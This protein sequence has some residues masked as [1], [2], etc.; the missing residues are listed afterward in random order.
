MSVEKG[1]NIFEAEKAE[2]NTE[3]G[4]RLIKDVASRHEKELREMIEDNE[5]ANILSRI[6]NGAVTTQQL[7]EEFQ[8]LALTE[9]LD[10]EKF[11]IEGG[12]YNFYGHRFEATTFFQIILNQYRKEAQSISLE[13][14]VLESEDNSNKT[15]IRLGEEDNASVVVDSNES[16]EVKI[17]QRTN[18]QAEVARL[19]QGGFYDEAKVYRKVVEFAETIQ[20]AG[21]RAML[22]GGC[23]RDELMGILP[24]D[25]DVEVYG[26]EPDKLKQ[27][28]ESFGQVNE[29][30]IAFGILKI[31]V[32]D[33]DID[34][35]LPRRES[36]TGSGH[37]DFSISADPSMS[38]KEAARRRDF[39]FNALAKDVLTGEVHDYFGG[40]ND[41]EQ[42]IMRVTDEE[43]F[44]DDPLRV[45]RG[46]QF[47]GRYG[48]KVDDRSSEIMREMRG[49]LRHL[50]KERLREEWVKLFTRSRKPSLGLQ[51]AMEWGIFHE[52]HPELIELPKTPQ[53][54]E[55]HPE[56]DVWIHTMMVV[57]EAAKIVEREQLKGKDA[58]VVML[59][60]FCHDFGKPNTT[61]ESDGR[62]RALGHEEAGVEPTIKFLSEIGIEASLRDTVA[63][64]VAQHLKPSMFYIEE[65]KKGKKISDGA[66][67]RLAVRISPANLKQL[68][69]VSESDHLGRGPFVDP[70]EPEKSLMPSEYPAGAWLLQRADSLGV[71]EAK[72]EPILFGR[73]LI[74]FGFRPGKLIGET[75]RVADDLHVKGY[76]RD[77]ILSIVYENKEKSLEDIIRM[78]S[79]LLA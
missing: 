55:W 18:A 56:G 1:G 76:S 74:A 16:S 52:L 49:E 15:E 40:I 5:G 7:V 64:L 79:E 71:Y 51:A 54:P 21:G 23:V 62:V 39:T 14:A 45:L 6:E 66:I 25:Y 68:V 38:V 17:I 43:R 70:V 47:V 48:F 24:K 29:V 2:T 78:M 77:E 61:E 73:D 58:L 26:I 22:V 46:V 3:K 12:R 13:R 32:E 69:C 57:D 11:Y 4:V 75:I 27:L 8:E 33:M 30:G 42:R 10:L 19:E 50:P 44:R 53:E 59:G 72:P 35:S 63:K 28:A 37:K 67:K 65:V 9:G 31:R 36:K 60:S 20:Q 41:I 34:V